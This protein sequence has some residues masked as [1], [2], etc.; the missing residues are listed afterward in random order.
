M[1]PPT[2]RM[3]SGPSLHFSTP[4]F[5]LTS[6]WPSASFHLPINESSSALTLNKWF[7][8]THVT[9]I[10]ILQYPALEDLIS[11]WGNINPSIP[12]SP[13]S[14]FTTTI[15]PA[16][17]YSLTPTKSALVF[18][19]QTYIYVN[20][21]EFTKVNLKWVMPLL[22]LITANNYYMYIKKFPVL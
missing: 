16:T 11:T 7:L 20:L 19:Q 1:F 17:S 22:R 10:L 4:P 14:Q 15:S 12:N 6:F 9:F 18:S 2:S 8:R 21:R 13:H 5:L 3:R